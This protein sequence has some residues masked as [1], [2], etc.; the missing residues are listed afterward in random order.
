MIGT[1]SDEL[2]QQCPFCEV[3]DIDID[4]GDN[5]ISVLRFQFAVEINWNPCPTSYFPHQSFSC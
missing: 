5:V 1:I 3:L 2:F 4:S